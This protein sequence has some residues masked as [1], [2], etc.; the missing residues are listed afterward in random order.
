MIKSDNRLQMA[1]TGVYHVPFPV[2]RTKLEPARLNGSFVPRPH[3]VEH[4]DQGLERPFT[5]FHAPAGSGKSTL[6]RQWLLRPEAPPAAWVLL[7]EEDNDLIRFATYI[8]SAVQSVFPGSCKQ[9]RSLLLLPPTIPVPLLTSTLLNELSDLPER[10][11]LVLEEYEAIRNEAIHHW[12]SQVLEHQPPTL[13]LVVVTRVKPPFALARLRQRRLVNVIR[14][15]DLRLTVEETAA[16][17]DQ[18]AGGAVDKE[19]AAT[20]QEQIEGWVGGLHLVAMSDDAQDLLREFFLQEV[21]ADHPADVWEFLLESSLPEYFSPALMASL[22]QVTPSVVA[23]QNMVQRLRRA[24]LFLNT[25]ASRPGCYC[26]HRLFREAL[27][28]ELAQRRSQD[29]VACMHRRVAAWFEEQ[30]EI[31]LAL[32]HW[33]AAGEQ[34]A[35]AELVEQQIPAALAGERLAA[36]AAWLERLPYDLIWQRPALLLADAW[37]QQERMF[38][39]NIEPQLDQVEYLL[40]K[41]NVAAPT[42]L[43]AWA[44]ALCSNLWYWRGDPARSLTVAQDACDLTSLADGFTGSYALAR[45]VMSR[46][47]A[48]TVQDALRQLDRA[49][50]QPGLP[51]A[52]KAQLLQARALADLKA[53]NLSQSERSAKALLRLAEKHAL[54]ASTSWAHY[55]LGRIC[56]EWDQLEEASGHFRAV[57]SAPNAAASLPLHDS[58]IGLALVHEIWGGQE[59]ADRLV[60]E[61]QERFQER[62]AFFLP[63]SASIEAHLALLRGNISAA[64]RLVDQLRSAPGED[65]L[66]LLETPQLTFIRILLAQNTVASLQKAMSALHVLQR[67]TQNTYNRLRQVEV[68]TLRAL[69]LEA[70]GETETALDILQQAVVVAGRGGMVRVF[71]D[72]GPPMAALLYRLTNSD[73]ASP[74][75]RHLLAAFPRLRQPVMLEHDAEVNDL[76]QPLTDREWEVLSL[77]GHRL[78]NKEIAQNLIISPNTVKKHASNIYQKLDVNSR[79]QAIARAHQLGLLSVTNE[80]ARFFAFT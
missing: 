41:G 36:L 28:L 60:A 67:V 59:T 32:T 55:L 43:K 54:A 29:E 3:L 31:K 24:S 8:V 73:A 4:L 66:L 11:V 34:Q 30:G 27:R 57:V 44:A 37:V 77:M 56:Y 40:D 69:V 45:L 70:L 75:A 17:L 79:R 35:A 10:F 38:L 9:T 53:G 76:L 71:V 33:L 1:A 12:L 61:I 18:V 62:D 78:S 74:Y 58:H 20:L 42:S 80:V 25:V 19:R 16:I 52:S 22:S 7:D 64:A 47:M 50:Q 65:S 49:L 26:Y 23:A 63:S 5:L 13:H 6:V 2:V 15:D 68:L 14:A 48:G 72:L 39:P 46:Q 21:L 51:P